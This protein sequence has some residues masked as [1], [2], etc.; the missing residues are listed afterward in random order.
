[1][2]RWLLRAERLLLLLL[3]LVLTAVH[4]RLWCA[5][6]LYR[7]PAPEFCALACCAAAAASATNDAGEE[8]N[9]MKNTC[10]HLL[11]THSIIMFVITGHERQEQYEWAA[12]KNYISV[13]GF[14]G[15]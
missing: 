6:P 13:V 7:F 4:A 11:K 2:A 15:A 5:L 9:P 8:A 10:N 1:M 14:A 3:S 12:K